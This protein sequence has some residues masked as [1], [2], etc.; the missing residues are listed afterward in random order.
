M[1]SILQTLFF[2]YG[3][4]LLDYPGK[5][6]HL[7]GHNGRVEV[8]FVSAELNA[9]GMVRDFSEIKA[10]L[11]NFLDGELDHVTILAKDDPLV[12]LLKE[13]KEP[14]FVMQEP[15]T[16][17]NLARLIFNYAVSR[18]LPVRAVRLWETES[19]CAEYREE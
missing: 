16:A 10:E 2:S 15:P 4:R 14:V 12:K 9:Q 18:G 19:S 13:I 3:H 17:E 8:E 11:K 6:A 7:H 1:Y 5:C